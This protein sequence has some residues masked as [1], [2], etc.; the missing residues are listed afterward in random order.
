MILS[1]TARVFEQNEFLYI[2]Y[3]FVRKVVE[4]I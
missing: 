1:E 2:N 3:V 4:K